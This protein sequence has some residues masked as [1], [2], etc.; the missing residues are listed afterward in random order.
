M[1]IDDASPYTPPE[2]DAILV[3]PNTIPDTDKPLIV[4]FPSR[5][6][7]NSIHSYPGWWR[8][9]LHSV[10]IARQMGAQRII[11]I[12]SDAF[13]ISQRLRDYIQSL[14]RGWT[15]LWASR[16]NMP[17]SAIQVIC[18]DQFDALAAFQHKSAEELDSDIAERLLPFTH[19]NK[20]FIGER[21]GEF[22]IPLLRTGVL[23]SKKFNRLAFF[24]KD[25]FRERIPAN[26][27]FA[28]QVTPDQTI[29]DTST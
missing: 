14:N 27:D 3:A 9:F 2:S 29:P 10:D 8:S 17:E 13:L 28:T 25:Y 16:F 21:Y 26:A 4:R 15:V 20:N 7:R 12:E 11:H 22:R 1:L 5:L 24:Q 19:V 23:R 18:D 6:G